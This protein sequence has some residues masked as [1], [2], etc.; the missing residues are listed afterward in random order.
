MAIS[1]VSLVPVEAHSKG[2]C[3]S[4]LKLSEKYG[5][6]SDRSQTFADSFDGLA[7]LGGSVEI[8]PGSI[9]RPLEDLPRSFL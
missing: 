7:I 1:S 9:L 2:P 3:H 6:A 8:Q 4:S 5:I